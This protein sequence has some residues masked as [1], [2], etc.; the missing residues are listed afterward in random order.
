MSLP[1]K[2]HRERTTRLPGFR[3]T[4]IAVAVALA[5]G[6]GVSEAATLTVTSNADAGAGTLRAQI[7]AA[8][9]GDTIVFDGDMNIALTT[10]A[11]DNPGENDDSMLVISRGLVIDGGNHTI[12]IDAG[13]SGRV[14]MIT[15]GN[16]TLSNLVIQGGDLAGNGGSGPYYGSTIGGDALG[17]G[18]AVT[19]AGTKL[20]LRGSTLT[21]NHA[22]GGGGACFSGAGGGAGWASGIGGSGGAAD[23]THPGAAGSAGTGGSGAFDYF[24]YSATPGHGGTSGAT[25]AGGSG[26]AGWGGAG[27]A[28]GTAGSA[29]IGYLGGGG[30]SSG[31]STGIPTGRGGHGAGAMYIGSGAIVYMANTDLH[32]N[33]GAGG[34]GSG[35]SS[36]VAG[37]NGGDGTGGIYNRGTLHYEASTVTHADNFGK[38]GGGGGNGGAG[39]GSAG[40]GSNAGTEWLAGS[41]TNDSSYDA[42]P[43]TVSAIARQTPGT[44][45]TNADALIFRVTFDESV[46]E[47]DTA[48]FAASGTTATVSDVSPVS[49]SVYDVTVSGGNLAG[50]DGTVSLALAATPTI[51]DTKGNALTD[52]TPASTETYAVDNTA[53]TVTSVMRRTPAGALTN[54]DGLVFRVTFG[55][56]V[57]GVT[58]GDFDPTGTSAGATGISVVSN[59][60]YDVT[61]SGGDLNSYEGTVGLAF[62]GGQDVTDTAGNALS[63]TAASGAND[64]FTLHNAVPGP[65]IGT[66]SVAENAANGSAVGTVTASD[67]FAVTYTLTDD[68]DGR[69]AISAGGAVTVADGSRLDYELAT[70]YDIVIRATDAAGNAA[71]TN[72]SVGITNLNDSPPVISEGDD[73]LAVTLSEDS[74]P[75]AFARTLHVSDADGAT[76]FTW[77][78]A[79][80][81]GHGTASASGGGSAKDITYIPTANYHG[82]DSFTVRVSDGVNTDSIQIDV[83]VEPVNDPPIVNEGAAT[84]LAV[85]E[86]GSGTLT[87]HGTDVEGDTLTWSVS[88][89]ASHGTASGGGTGASQ[90][91]S[92]TPDPDFT[93]SDSFVVQVSD[94]TATAIT[95]VNVTVSVPAAEAPTFSPAGGSYKG[96]V[97][98]TLSSA[99]PGATIRYTLDHTTPGATHGT[100]VPNGTTITLTKS[101]HLEAIAQKRG[102]ADSPVAAADYTVRR[103][104]GGEG[105]WLSALAALFFLRRRRINGAPHP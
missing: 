105:T 22:A 93:G 28:G 39:A 7:A 81:P 6:G 34:G 17:A 35:G 26:G 87:L 54:A 47:V 57:A 30:G 55:E 43:P 72:Q 14:F 77:S 56:E 92:Y 69:F 64:T 76:T 10:V 61:V 102:L 18:I 50:L 23:A 101:A 66:L 80:A 46:E 1:A 59:S 5:L 37:G 48:D 12:T 45:R 70:S 71:T 42:G 90:A 97:N 85:T 15:A 32:S 91:I 67:L 95:T 62:S 29:A 73:A 11:Q 103:G 58:T 75:T 38:G 78:M 2:L 25:G 19:G 40:S 31:W 83:T 51:S 100:T 4:A 3:R 20:T 8:G 98:V 13:N 27:A 94:G 96:E 9:V 52:T 79:S 82:S 104:G 24:T 65:A 84:S 33:L 89:A 86:N 88:G 36:G 68:A 99:T 16:V 21:G 74:V 53:P 49:G 44:Q 60:V 63:N 41:G